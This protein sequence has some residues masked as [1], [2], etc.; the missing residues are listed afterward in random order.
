MHPKTTREVQ[1]WLQDVITAKGD[2]LGS[3]HQARLRY[4]IDEADVIAQKG[5]VSVYTRL[6]VYA[7]G[8]F[9]R[10]YECLAA[11][12]PLLKKFLGND[13]FFAFSQAFLQ[14]V[15]STSYTLHD[16]GE[17]F[18]QYLKATRPI[19]D[20]P[21]LN[22]NFN[23]PVEL[24][25]LER[26]RQEVVRSKG[27]EDTL[28]TTP[29]GLESIFLSAAQMQV[30]QPESLR[31]A[32]F[33]FPMKHFV[34]SLIADDPE[35]LTLPEPAATFMAISRKNYHITMEEITEW[36]YIFLQ[37]SR[38]NP[39]LQGA[40]NATA[41]LIN[42]PIGKLMAD[43]YIWLPSLLANNFVVVQES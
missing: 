21:L 16:L 39:N 2:L 5:N 34:Q 23:L 7:S 11:D 37:Q 8:Y 33:G 36:Q 28:V 20:D 29:R 19:T 24:A 35:A 42:R 18:V 1:H 41:R 17:K 3:L 31:L 12:F 13:V 27:N 40:I 43:L 14:T 32:T 22:S 38:H 10:L 26:I 25:R 30:L 4:G 6:N 15:P 9:M